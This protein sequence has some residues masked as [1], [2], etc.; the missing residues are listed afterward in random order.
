M[1]L[2]SICAQYAQI[3]DTLPVIPAP[4]PDAAPEIGGMG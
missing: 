2:A 1:S 3:S 4:A